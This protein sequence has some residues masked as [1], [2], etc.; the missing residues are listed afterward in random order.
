MINYYIACVLIYIIIF[1]LFLRKNHDTSLVPRLFFVAVIIIS[2]V[3]LFYAIKRLLCLDEQNQLY[4][5]AATLKET[6]YSL[7]S[8]TFYFSK[9][10][11]WV[12]T[13]LFYT[14]IF[15][16]PIAIVSIIIKKDFWGKLSLVT[17]LIIILISGTIFEHLLFSSKYPIER[18][19]LFFIPIY[20]L[21]IYYL[22]IHI[23]EFYRPSKAIYIP[24]ILVLCAPI[25]YH[26]L[27]NV[28][29]KYT[30][31]WAYDAHTKTVM[32]IIDENTRYLQSNASISNTLYLEPSINFYIT[33][34]KIKLNLTDRGGV[35]L[36]SDFLYRFN[37]T[38]SPEHFK[39]LF[40]CHDKNVNASLL[41]KT[42]TDK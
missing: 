35:N 17:C 12:S 14:F 25:F 11:S 8:A 41:M 28:N 34:R 7:I 3:P 16:F 29:L 6:V 10:P 21:F 2:A 36:N 15:S 1:L 30:K 23:F 5:G 42:E 40:E 9:Y 4:Y 37:D 19:G 27:A 38:S 39:V 20:G 26:F 32:K 24:A 33:T 22:A 31:T 18:T 13:L